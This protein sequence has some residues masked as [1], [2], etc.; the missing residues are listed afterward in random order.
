MAISTSNVVIATD[1]FA[2]WVAKTNE[3]AYSL[4]TA[5]LSSNTSA[6]VTSGNSYLNGTFSAN[7][8]AV[9]QG[10]RGGNVESSNTTQLN[11]L[12]S[13][14][15]NNLTLYVSGQ[16]AL[17]TA[18][19]NQLVDSVSTTTYRSSKYILQVNTA[20]GYQCSEILVLHDGTN[21]YVTEYATLTTNGTQGVFSTNINSG[22]IQL[23]VTP[24]QTTSTVTFQR[25]SIVT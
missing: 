11:I 12:S 19:A 5:V 23:L 18:T 9:V 14:L 24:T 3:I 16:V 13:V 1:T 17:A 6:G 8:V 4:S 2:S 25:T 21:S 20:V 15:S 22:S 10:L 7:T